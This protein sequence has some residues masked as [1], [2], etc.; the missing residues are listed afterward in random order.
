MWNLVDG[1]YELMTKELKPGETVEY[2]IVLDWDTETKCLGNL[3]NVARIT[4]TDNIPQFSETTLEDNEDSC[5]LILSIKTGED[6]TI[7]LIISAVIVITAGAYISGW[8][9]KKLI[10]K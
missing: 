6:I 9:L 2:Q 3:N 4:E 1:K 7:I 5:E 10:S 8:T